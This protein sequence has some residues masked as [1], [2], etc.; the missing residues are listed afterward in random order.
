MITSIDEI[1]EN[2]TSNLKASAKKKLVG[3]IAKHVMDN[4]QTFTLRHLY[5]MATRHGIS[6]AEIARYFELWKNAEIKRGT[7]KVIPSL[8][9]GEDGELYQPTHVSLP[10]NLPDNVIL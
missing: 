8:F 1:L 7:L 3:E 2:Q 9:P 6:Y 5:S 4:S 10:G